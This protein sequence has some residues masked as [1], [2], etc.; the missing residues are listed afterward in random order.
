[1]DQDYIIITP[2]VD[3]NSVQ[4]FNYDQSVNISQNFEEIKPQEEEVMLNNIH[5]NELDKF[6]KKRRKPLYSVSIMYM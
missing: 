3:I 6:C 1:M 5:T 4:I 2:T